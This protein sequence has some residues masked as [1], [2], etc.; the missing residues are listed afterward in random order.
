VGRISAAVIDQGL[1]TATNFLL[2]LVAAKML[3]VRDFGAFGVAYT[4]AVLIV[5]SARAAVASPAL[6]LQEDAGRDDADGPLGAAL[7]TGLASGAA[8]AI[9]ALFCHSDVRAVLL[10]LAAVLPLVL[11]QDTGRLVE[12]AELQPTRALTLDVIWTIAMVAGLIAL[13]A[14]GVH[15]TATLLLLVWGAAGGL[16]GLWTLWQHGRRI[17][18]PS[19]HWLRHS[20]HYAWRYFVVFA[21]TLGAFQVSALLLGVVSGVQAVGAVQAVQ[22][23]FG[24]LQNLSTGLMVAFVPDTTADTPLRDQRARLLGVTLCLTAIALAITGMVMVLPDNVGEMVLGDSWSPAK[25]LILAAGLCAAGFGITSGPMIGLRAARAVHESLVVGLQ[26]SA[27]QLVIPV[28]GAVL[29]DERGFM[30]GL[31]ATW[32]IGIAMWVHLYRAVEGGRPVR[33]TP[34]GAG[35]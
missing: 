30:W 10:A 6:V 13:A 21:S 17:P 1:S 23:L 27:F 31:V 24:P 7:A 8:V 29:A 3:G 19:L 5:G 14:S 4:V 18:R 2:T 16:S 28:V 9:A 35:T 32:V 26:T 15:A 12:F 11:V 20:W 25:P 22:V 33:P 34:V